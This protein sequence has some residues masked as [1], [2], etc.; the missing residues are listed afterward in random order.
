MKIHKIFTGEVT[1]VFDTDTGEWVDQEFIAT[2]EEPMCET[3]YG[4]TEILGEDVED[5]F[6]DNDLPILLVQPF[7]EKQRIEFENGKCVEIESDG[8]GNGE[9]KSDLKRL[10]P[11]CNEADCYGECEMSQWHLM[12]PKTKEI[13][14]SQVFEN[15]DTTDEELESL[16]EMMAREKHNRSIDVL[17]SFLLS[18]VC[19]K[20]NIT[21][22][23]DALCLSVE[24]VSETYM[25]EIR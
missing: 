4:E 24:T 15:S 22:F 14:R 18:L 6:P 2:S 19:N 1:Q 3:L 9:I 25:E 23:A 20:Q 21:G 12:D 7:Q 11:Y 13:Q 10:C 8:E 5:L 16:D 17:E